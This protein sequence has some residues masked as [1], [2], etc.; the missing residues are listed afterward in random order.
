MSDSDNIDN[1][2]KNISPGN[3]R[4][5][6]DDDAAA[7]E[8][9]DDIYEV[10]EVEEERSDANGRLA[11]QGGENEVEEEIEEEEIEEIVVEVVIGEAVVVEIKKDNQN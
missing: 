8:N 5:D 1:A 6:L 2:G 4:N 7:D 9:D 3:N 11:V 10:E